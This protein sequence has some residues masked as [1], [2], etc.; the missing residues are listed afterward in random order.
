M[1]KGIIIGA[2]L[3]VALVGYGVLDTHTLER[4]GT[5]VKNTVNLVAQKVDEVTR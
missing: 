2:V 5:Q 4:A 3:V 1:I